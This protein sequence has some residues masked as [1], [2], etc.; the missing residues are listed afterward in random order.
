MGRG[1]LN[2]DVT[3]DFVPDYIVGDKNGNPVGKGGF[4]LQCS[5]YWPR[6]PGKT[7]G[8]PCLFR[9]VSPGG[10]PEG[11][12][13]NQLSTLACFIRTEHGWQIRWDKV[14]KGIVNYYFNGDFDKAMEATGC[15]KVEPLTQLI[16]AFY[17]FLV[18]NASFVSPEVSLSSSYSNFK[19]IL[20]YLLLGLKDKI[21]HLLD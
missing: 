20:P 11:P 3:G 16:P 5:D 2:E 9:P 18:K 10:W 1:E 12:N 17:F 13:S 15:D 6:Q 19:R 14:M 7:L 8:G 4:Q 21:Y